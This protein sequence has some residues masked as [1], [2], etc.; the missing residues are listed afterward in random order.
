MPITM[1][2]QHQRFIAPKLDIDEVALQFVRLH[3]RL[4]AVSEVLHFHRD[5]GTLV[6]RGAVPTFYI[7]QVLQEALR[8][9]PGV[10]RIDNQVEVTQRT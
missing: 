3:P 9:V 6:V 8:E 10:A 5:G 2:T 1:R 7:K 4:Y